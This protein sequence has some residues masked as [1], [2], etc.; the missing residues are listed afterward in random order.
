MTIPHQPRPDK[1]FD[2]EL[3]DVTKRFGS[4]VANDKVSMKVAA[5]TFHALIG[6]N[7]A[8]KSTLV[9]CIMGFHTAEE[10]DILV[11]GKSREIRSPYD[12]YNFGIG[13]VY[14]HFTLVPAM[15]VAENLLLSRPDMPGLINWKV[16]MERLR[17]FMRRAPFQVDLE[18]PASQLAAGQKQKV[19]ILKQL[20]LESKFLILDEPTSVLTPTEADEVL[21]LIKESVKAGH[22]SVLLI[23][24]KFREVMGFCDDVTIL[25]RGKVAGAGKVKNLSTD[26]MAAMMMGGQREAKI[27]AKQAR[28]RGPLALPMP[29]CKCMKARSS[30]LPEFPATASANWWKSSPGSVPPPAGKCR[31]MA[32]LIMPRAARRPRTKYFCCPK[33]LCATRACRR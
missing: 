33:N 21:G 8:G 31:F 10:G 29:I 25:R 24:H 11:H 5:G 27:V 15:T 2:L 13:M 23:T 7:G 14:Q 18:T 17:D 28:E 19:E 30:A 9:K 20:Y 32:N 6:E 16:E 26:Q 1:P 4:F 12:A 22:L 3:F